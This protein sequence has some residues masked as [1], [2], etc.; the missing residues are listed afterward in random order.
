M[1]AGISAPRLRLLLPP[2]LMFSQQ[3]GCYYYTTTATACHSRSSSP[4]LPL[5]T[6]LTASSSRAAA[7]FLP[8]RTTTLPFQTL[9]LLAL[10][11]GRLA[12]VRAAGS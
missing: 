11:L 8:S 5:P 2:P 10:L 7:M 6:Q 3:A 9:L 12:G 4:A 1:T